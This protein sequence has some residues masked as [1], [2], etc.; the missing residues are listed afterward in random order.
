[1]HIVEKMSI[2]EHD[3]LNHGGVT[4]A[5]LGDSVT[6]GCFEIYK[7]SNGGLE[8]VYDQ[9]NSYEAGVWRILSTLYPS[10]A[11]NIINAGINGDTAAGGLNRLERDVLRHDPD[12]CIVCYG[13]NDCSPLEGGI[14][15]YTLSLRSIF[16][17]IRESGSEIIFMTPNM[18]NTYVSPHITD[19]DFID[20]AARVAE[21]QNSGLFDS[22]IESARKLC[23]ELNIKVCDC[24]AIWKKLYGN[25][26]DTTELLSNKIN[27]PTREMNKLF[28][29]ELVRSMM[30]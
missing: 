16:K 6:Q 12:L 23:R 15:R 29:Y 11:V 14:E 2:K 9:Q 20:I 18:M 8:T 5:F 3:N 26:V 4:I 19:P 21:K 30:M 25:G 1:M 27:H 22:Y 17:K 13:L 7:K 24:Y 10:C 28:S